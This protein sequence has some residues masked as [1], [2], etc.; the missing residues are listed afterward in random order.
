MAK[1]CKK[2]DPHEICEECPEWIFT[3]ADLI[4]C[5]M[6]LFV[7]LWVLKT[8]GQPGPPQE[9]RNQKQIETIAGIRDGFGYVPD[10]A[11]ADPVDQLLI[12]RMNG[13]GERGETELD[14]QAPDGTQPE[15]SVIRPGREVAIGGR[16]GFPR[17]TAALTP[18][19]RRQLDQTADLIRGHRQIAL[20]KGHA[21][22]DDFDEDATAGARMDLSLRRAQA[23]ADHLV[24]KGVSPD[25]L[26]VQGCGPFEPVVQR[27]YRPG[28]QAANRRVEVIATETLVGQLQD[29]SAPASPVN[30]EAR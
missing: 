7:I 11:S 18:D 14:P 17:G 21:A 27:D 10:P 3:L 13:P 20:V 12:R 19:V 15:T 28:A 23:V 2:C 9:A 29:G 1:G 26:R 16:I 30:A 25:V 24:A 8:E 4:M 22:L 5:M 6:G